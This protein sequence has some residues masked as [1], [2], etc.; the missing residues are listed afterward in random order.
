MVLTRA[1][2][3]PGYLDPLRDPFCRNFDDIRCIAMM[4]HVLD[5]NIHLKRVNFFVLHNVIA[6]HSNPP[7]V[8]SDRPRRN[9]SAQELCDFGIRQSHVNFIWVGWFRIEQWNGSG[10]WYRQ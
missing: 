2:R 8:F 5:M 3:Q 6:K 10:A 7:L 9:F 1:G 4:S